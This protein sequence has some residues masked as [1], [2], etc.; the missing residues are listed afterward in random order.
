MKDSFNYK[1]VPRDYLHCFN[2]DCPRASECLP[3]VVAMNATKSAV[4]IRTLNPAAYPKNAKRCPHFRSATSTRMAWGMTKLFDKLS[5]LSARFI[6]K[7]IRSLYPTKGYY[8]VLNG[9]RAITP[10]E[11][12]TIANIFA[13]HGI[14]TPPVFDRYTEE[15]DWNA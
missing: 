1:S 4:F 2:R 9:E 14:S 15:Y 8:R 12:A 11:Q 10:T 3:Y 5:Y 7:D 6:R 13:Q